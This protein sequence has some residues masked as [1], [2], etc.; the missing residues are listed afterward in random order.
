MRQ[1]HVLILMVF[2]AAGALHALDVEESQ[3]V[4]EA[5]DVGEEFGE[6][7]GVRIRDFDA[8]T[9]LRLEGCHAGVGRE[10]AVEQGGEATRTG[11][12]AARGTDGAER[13]VGGAPVAQPPETKR[14]RI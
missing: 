13:P 9:G 7:E 5:V 6:G 8:G 14:S 2:F 3:A 10:K 12:D 11:D 1:V 4:G